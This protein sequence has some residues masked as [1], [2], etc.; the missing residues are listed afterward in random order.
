[1]HAQNAADGATIA[2]VVADQFDQSYQGSRPPTTIS[3]YDLVA[4][5][6]FDQALSQL[7]NHLKADLPTF[8]PL[9][10]QAGSGIQR[11]FLPEL[12]DA[13][14][15][16]DSLEARVSDP[17]IRSDI[18]AL[19]AAGTA[20]SFRLRTH[21]RNG[22]A[23]TLG[24][25]DVLR[26][27]GLHVLLPDISTAPVM[28]PTGP[29]SLQSYLAM[30][31]TTSWGQFLAAYAPATADVTD[32]GANRLET[33][34][35][36]S[37]QAQAAGV[38]IDLWVLEP[39]GTLASPYNGSVSPNGTLTDD[40]YYTNQS[41]EGYL[42]NRFVMNGTYVWYALL[43]SDPQ[44]VQPQIDFF[45]RYGS[46]TFVSI[47]GSGPYPQLTRAQS[48]SADPDPTFGEANS[49]AY[50]DLVAVANV[51]FGP[52]PLVATVGAAAKSLP[53]LISGGRGA[54]VAMSIRGML[55]MRP[56]QRQI[57]TVRAL[58][59]HRLSGLRRFQAS[60][61]AR[62]RMPTSPMLGVAK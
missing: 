28:G 40:S 20:S 35:V 36:W 33:Y 29:R 38:D 4:F 14:N 19:R 3:A 47:F 27:S 34:L 41:V 16:A 13:L 56:T 55:G 26:S 21:A 25:T 48:V 1:M 42:T 60:G 43:V 54:P 12:A 46:A 10:A 50:S 22:G 17:T 52:A 51:T 53:R 59:E 44:T 2:T 7:G 23:A 31:G 49:G 45:Y 62:L 15:F 9:V 18:A 30:F 11:F 57:T 39:D 6:A 8:G 61:L 32:L 24:G 37:P 58:L 5:G